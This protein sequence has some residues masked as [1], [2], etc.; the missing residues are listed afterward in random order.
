MPIWPTADI[1]LQCSQDWLTD[2]IRPAISLVHRC[3]LN[4]ALRMKHAP[5]AAARCTRLVSC[6]PSSWRSCLPSDAASPEPSDPPPS[7]RQSHPATDPA[8]AYSPAPCAC[9]RATKKTGTSSTPSLGL[10]QT[11][12]PPPDG[13]D[14]PQTQTA[15]PRH[16][17]PPQTSRGRLQRSQP[18]TGRILLRRRQQHA[19]A[20]LAWFVTAVHRSCGSPARAPSC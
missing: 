16:R 9:S 14:P 10:D 12:A 13:Y 6:A 1:P 3:Q 20:P 2:V 19:A 11:P 15:E 17:L 4:A 8:L 7:L 18:T 5:A